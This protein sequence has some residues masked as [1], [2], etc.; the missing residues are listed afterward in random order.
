MKIDSTIKMNDGAEIPVLGFGAYLLTG[1]AAYEATRIA[2]DAGYRH[3]DT[4]AFYA[5]EAE[6]GKA[7][8]DS[9]LPRESVFLTTKVWNSDQGYKSTIAAFYESL[10]KTGL[11]YID[12]YL[13]HWPEPDLRMETWRAMEELRSKEVCRSIGVSNYEI[14]HLEEVL[15]KGEIPP[16][17]NQVEFSPFLYRKE[18]LRYC[19]KENIVLEAYSP[20][21]RARRLNDERL[22]EL[23]EKYGK[24]PAQILIRW[25]LQKGA[26]V[27][28]KASSEKRIKENAEVFDF[29]ITPED[30]E[31]LDGF[32][33]N[34]RIA[35]D[36]SNVR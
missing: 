13:I 26:V 9:G 6:I 7:I 2:L 16:A 20:L 31:F 18:L 4:A 29:E 30:M 1:K 25:S 19:Q 17:V 5:N 34:Y 15:S 14:R 10:R 3:I 28:P 33:E 32:H 11:D 35:W 12:L 23:A 21:T 24:T 22:K 8:R 27:L 36:P